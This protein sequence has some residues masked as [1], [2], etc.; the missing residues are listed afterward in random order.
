MIQTWKV[1]RPGTQ[2]GCR[3]DLAD[4]A[5]VCRL[6]TSQQTGCDSV[7]TQEADSRSLAPAL[8][9]CSSPNLDRR[10]FRVS[11]SPP[12]SE[13]YTNICAAMLLE[14]TV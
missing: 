10:T 2:R 13:K 7:E 9:H 12:L 11:G 3:R 5:R 4:R 8:L 14:R 1:Q 6:G